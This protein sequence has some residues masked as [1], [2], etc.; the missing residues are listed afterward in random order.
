MDRYMG[1]W[2]SPDS[3]S[4][5]FT[6]VDEQ[7]IPNFHIPQVFIFYVYKCSSINSLPHILNLPHTLFQYSTSKTETETEPLRYPFAGE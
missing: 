1:F 7:K 6:H 4:I 3:R 2:W 5:V